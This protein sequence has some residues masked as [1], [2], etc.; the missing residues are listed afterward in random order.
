M[1]LL[2]PVRQSVVVHDKSINIR[3]S[4]Q[5]NSS[6]EVLRKI[7][8]YG[9]CGGATGNSYYLHYY[10]HPE[11]QH[12]VVGEVAL[13]GDFYCV[14]EKYEIKY[15]KYGREFPKGAIHSVLHIDA[16]RIVIVQKEYIYRTMNAW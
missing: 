10:T 1:H 13:I 7:Y 5:W 9:R 16:S 2:L 3:N 12:T 6:R 15:T 11:I 14:G 4:H 8:L